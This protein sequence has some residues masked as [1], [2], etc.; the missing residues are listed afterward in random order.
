[1][2]FKFLINKKANIIKL[3]FKAG[4]WRCTAAL[5]ITG[6][7]S[8]YKGFHGGALDSFLRIVWCN[9]FRYALKTKVSVV[10]HLI[11]LTVGHWA[12][13][14]AAPWVPAAPALAAKSAATVYII[15]PSAVNKRMLFVITFSAPFSQFSLITRP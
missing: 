7:A 10:V 6:K 12:G 5:H 11:I 8:K 4:I 15:E 3:E 14:P 1:M 13:Q 2:N 9:I